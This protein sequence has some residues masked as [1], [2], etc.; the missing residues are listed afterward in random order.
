MNTKTLIY[1]LALL[2]LPL[3][4]VAQET[5]HWFCQAQCAAFRYG[6][7][8]LPVVLPAAV[9]VGDA[10]LIVAFADLIADCQKQLVEADAG[11]L[12]IY[13]VTQLKAEHDE[14][15]SSSSSYSRTPPSYATWSTPGFGW[16][17]RGYGAWPT[18][19]LTVYNPGSYSSSS[20]YSHSEHTQVDA[21]FALA[22]DVCVQTPER[23][24]VNLIKRARVRYRGNGMP[25]GG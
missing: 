24:D 18:S 11:Q 5:S 15:S 10:N 12:D 20:S 3:T 7:T 14:S 6:I 2:G 8:K 19:S 1:S 16:L 22:K 17:G 25:L 23:V 13:L 21:T 9:G 4:S